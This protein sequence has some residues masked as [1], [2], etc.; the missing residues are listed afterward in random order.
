MTKDGQN[1][2]LKILED[3]PKHVYFF[4]CTTDPQK[5]IPTIRTRCTDMMVEPLSDTDMGVLLAR[6]AKREQIE[7]TSQRM[8]KIIEASE[9]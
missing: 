4:L 6:V 5:L 3:T 7:L 2:M 9:G 1:A 8:D